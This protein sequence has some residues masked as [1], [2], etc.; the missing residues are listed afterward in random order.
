MTYR[1]TG[2]VLLALYFLQLWLN[3]QWPYLFSLQA[4]ENYK[5]WSGIVLMIYLYSQWILTYKRVYSARPKNNNRLLS[6]HKW[7]GAFAPV[8]FY[9]HSAQLGHGYLLLMSFIFFINWFIGIANPEGLK[10][11][12]YFSNYYSF[13]L[14]LHIIFSC[15]ICLIILYHIYIVAYY[16]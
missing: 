12:R 4:T 7:L 1:I 13:W 6:L 10:I 15:L 14:R 9:S 16:K 11:Q 8:F 5:V 3:I 2:L